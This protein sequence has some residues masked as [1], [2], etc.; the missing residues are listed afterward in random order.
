MG[1]SEDDVKQLAE[2]REWLVK[3]IAEKEEELERL[4]MTLTLIDSSLKQLSFKPAVMLSQQVGKGTEE[5]VR[6]LRSKDNVVLGSAITAPNH[7]TIVPASE[8]KLNVNT[9]PFKSFFLNRILEGMKSKDV[10]RVDR[11]ELKTDQVIDYR[12]EEENGVIQKII[13][14]NYR[15]KERL[16]EIINTASWVFARMLEKTR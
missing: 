15:D 7:I 1:Y 10:E 14:S 2:L 16:N 5:E 13:I 3:Q 4:R 12:V 8:M 11:G 9:P 6:Q